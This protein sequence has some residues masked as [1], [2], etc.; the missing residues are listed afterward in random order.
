MSFRRSGPRPMARGLADGFVFLILLVL[1]TVVA[2]QTG[3][4]DLGAGGYAAVDGDSLRR[5]GADIRLYGIDAPELHQSCSDRNGR[6][7]PCGYQARDVL[8]RLIDRG[9]V[10]CTAVDGDRYGRAVALCRA[11]DLDLAGE[12]VRRGF[13]LAY[14]RHSLDYLDEEAEARRAR[15]GLWQGRFENP[16]VW[17]QSHAGR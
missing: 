16:D 4:L 5:D 6:D 8:R 15:R 11:G 12:M 10:T 3:L 13:A 9:A 17:R 7:Y 14:R 1:V 2:R